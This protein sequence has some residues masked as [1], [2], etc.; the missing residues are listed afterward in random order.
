MQ[1]IV[2]PNTIAYRKSYRQSDKYK[3]YQKKYS[4]SD[5]NISYQ[6]K[7]KQ[8]NKY[9]EQQS[10]YRQTDKFKAVLS[11]YQKTNKYLTSRLKVYSISLEDYNKMLE[12]QNGVCA[13]C[14]KKPKERLAVD[15]NHITGKVRGLLCIKCN[16]GISKFDDNIPTMEKAIKYISNN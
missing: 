8:S 4:K 13:I 2:N 3:A 1:K 5:K 9:K 12:K 14:G 10:Q 16:L 11:K 6:K 7:Y 15:H